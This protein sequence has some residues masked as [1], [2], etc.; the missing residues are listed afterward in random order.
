MQTL[1]GGFSKKSLRLDQAY[2]DWTISDSLR[3]TGGKMPNP[4]YRPGWSHL[5]WDDDINP[6]GLALGYDKTGWIARLAGFSIEERGADKDSFMLAAQIA[7]RGKLGLSS[8]WTTG[9]SFYENSEVV[10]QAPFYD[11]SAQGNSLDTQGLYAFGYRKIQWFGD[12]QFDLRGRPL[13]LFADAVSNRASDSSDYG[14]SLGARYG[15]ASAPG[16]SEWAI[17]YADLDADAVLGT[18]TDGDFAGGGTGTRGLVVYWRHAVKRN[19]S[20][21]L[22][23]FDNE[24]EN[25]SDNPLQYRRFQADLDFKF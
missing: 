22:R 8:Q 16:D 20:V 13:R 6:E 19:L 25:G 7:L 14:Y 2:F 3:L 17:A 18:F 15:G 1:G 21:R 9:I 10:G 5:V 12:V 23:Y 24:R 4:M 11:G